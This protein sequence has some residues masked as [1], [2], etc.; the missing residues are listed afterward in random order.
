MTN[1]A[2]QSSTQF[3]E[4]LEA[5]QNKFNTME[6]EV[7]ET[8]EDKEMGVKGFVVV[9]NT[10]IAKD[11]I[12]GP[13]GKGGTR[14]T[15][16][17]TLADVKML[18]CKMALKNAAAG[19]PL[20]GSKAGLVANPD[21]PDFEKKYRRF[22]TLCK[23][24][25]RENGGKFGGFGF[26][27]GARPIHP[28][29][30]CDELKSTKSFTGKPLNMGGTDY[31]VEGL[32]GLGVATAAKSLLDF[33]GIDPKLTTYAVQG[34]G[35]M[36]SAVIRYFSEFKTQLVAISDLRIGG[37]WEFES[38]ASSK[39][40]KA[41]AEHRLDDLQKLLPEEATLTSEDCNEALYSKCDIIIPC[42]VQS[43]IHADNVDKIQARYIVEGANGPCDNNIYP[44]LHQK[45]IVVIP[46]FIANSGGIIAAFVEMSSTITPEENL[47]NR[48]LVLQSKELTIEKISSNVKIVLDLMHTHKVM[49]TQAA[50]YM[51]LSRIF[52]VKNSL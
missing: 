28:I 2:T 34:L 8:L 6:P 14:I 22:V 20:G 12:L 5:L 17:V 1:T 38:F 40:I 19:L 32:A 21:A 48:T 7:V 3:M 39:I 13:C 43:V 45:K 52:K 29:W 30:A 31:D 16:D 10:D 25:L 33:Y 51:A 50:L 26:D 36:G 9:W 23:P 46:D 49:P 18:A 44:I 24:L 35:A 15:P 47:K 41:I 11:G 37:T 27:I 4:E 42:A